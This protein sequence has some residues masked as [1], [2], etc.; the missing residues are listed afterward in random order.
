MSRYSRISPFC[1]HT[2]AKAP[3]LDNR[4]PTIFLWVLLPLGDGLMVGW[5]DGGTP[6]ISKNSIKIE[7]IKI[8]QIF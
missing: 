6:Q 8:I 1:T 5:V 4:S 7:Q 2:V 3:G